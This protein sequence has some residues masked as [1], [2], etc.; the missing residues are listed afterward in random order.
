MGASYKDYIEQRAI[1]QGAYMV[2]HKTTIRETAKAFGI[3]KS[4]THKDMQ[5]RLP[6]IDRVLHRLVSEVI[7]ANKEEGTMRGGI[8]TRKAYERLRA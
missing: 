1:D 3:S 2:R 8:A 6:K 4:T 5:E 7:E